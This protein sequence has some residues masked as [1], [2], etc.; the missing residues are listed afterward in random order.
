MSR[1]LYEALV[2][3]IGLATDHHFALRAAL[4]EFHY[5]PVA[6]TFAKA[7]QSGAD[8]KIVYDGES[9]YKVE[10]ERTIA[11]A[12]LDQMGAVKARTVSEGIRHNKFV[13]LIED[14]QPIAVEGPIH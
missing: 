12:G 13:V 14:D 7:V 8:V 10:N 9:S 3:F 2:S 6:N 5:Q 1:G 4:Y 11:K